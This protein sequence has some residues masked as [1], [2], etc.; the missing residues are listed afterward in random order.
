MRFFAWAP[1]L[2]R[3]QQT[4]VINPV[5]GLRPLRSSDAPAA[6]DGLAADDVDPRARATLPI[7]PSN[8][9]PSAIQNLDHRAAPF[10][11]SDPRLLAPDLRLQ[12]QGPSPPATGAPA[13]AAF[14]RA[15]T[16]RSK[17]G[18]CSPRARTHPAPARCARE[19]HGLLARTPWQ[20]RGRTM[21]PWWPGPY[22]V[23]RNRNAAPQERADM[24]SFWTRHICRLKSDATR[25]AHPWSEVPGFMVLATVAVRRK[26]LAR[27]VAPHCR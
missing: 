17:T 10:L 15:P 22:E 26:D 9:L 23:V 19:A 20:R 1:W 18:R 14:R 11:P 2:T 13:R 4:V 3:A 21:S 7:S 25:P 24:V 6:A 5:N 8:W 27:L 16:C 12:H